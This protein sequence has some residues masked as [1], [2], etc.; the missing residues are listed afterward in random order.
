[1][2]NGVAIGGAEEFIN[3]V[4][5]NFNEY[6][7]VAPPE[8]I[9]NLTQQN[10]KKSNEEYYNRNKGLTLRQ[11]ID[12]QLISAKFQEHNNTIS[13]PFSFSYD[14]GIIFYY[15]ISE[16]FL[17]D[18]SK[19]INYD[20]KLFV[21]DKF[22]EIEDKHPVV[23]DIKLQSNPN[24]SS[25]FINNDNTLQI[26]DGNL[27]KT[28]AEH[29]MGNLDDTKEKIIVS[30]PDVKPNEISEYNKNESGKLLKF[31]DRIDTHPQSNIKFFMIHFH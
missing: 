12:Q 6:T 10:I 14:K 28:D 31:E 20:S 4:K 15:K 30:Q 25:S 24:N 26:D 27:N 7:Y 5:K 13:Q 16:N 18:K 19:W 22:F 3:Y 2:S 9:N 8:I 29:L 11:K 21:E 1:M 23:N 17:P